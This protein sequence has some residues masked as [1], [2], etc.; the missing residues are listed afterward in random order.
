LT[1][2]TEA[3]GHEAEIKCPQMILWTGIVQN[4]AWRLW[5]IRDTERPK[6]KRARALLTLLPACGLTRH[7]DVS[8]FPEKYHAGNSAS[9][10][11]GHL[12]V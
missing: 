10:P 4:H 11:N 2:G 12:S 7:E 8:G 1:D 3:I 5:Q 9:V 6:G